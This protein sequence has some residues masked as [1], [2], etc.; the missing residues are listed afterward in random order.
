MAA[1]RVIVWGLGGMGSAAAAS[2]AAR[3]ADVIGLE[4]FHP[5]HDHGSSHGDSRIFRKAYFEHPD[6]V[7]LLDRAYDAWARLEA[8]TGEPLLN[9][10]G[11]LMIGAPDSAVVAG[12]LA[13]V[14]RWDLAHE[15]LDAAAMARRFPQFRLRPHD[16]A[17]FEADAGYLRP[18]VAVG[19]Q[20][21]R[22]E[23]AGAA[24]RFGVRATDWEPR[25]DGVAVAVDGETIEADH[26]VITA[27]AWA[28]T[29]LAASGFPLQAA[30]AVMYR[31]AP[32]DPAAFAPARFP[33]FVYD[34]RGSAGEDDAL[35]GV[36][37]LGALDAAG[38]T[39]PAAKVGFHYRLTPVDPDHVDRHVTAEEIAAIRAVLAERIPGLAGECVAATTCFYTMTPDEHFVIG[40]LPGAAGTVS[41][42]AGFSGHG[43]K[44][45]PI[46]GEILADL[47][48]DGTTTAPI[49]LFDPLRF[50][51]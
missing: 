5:V 24:L 33:A 7:P 25:G 28:G 36:G 41:V 32:D 2:L 42:A 37:D 46:V 45:T 30:R 29:A 10:C 49:A 22:A 23:A 17:V 21:R 44:F 27:G 26:L 50:T 39:V 38:N 35:Y 12:T 14:Q 15:S 51:R 43:F 13:S 40:P 16:V 3:G 8:A 18:E 11:A 1:P 34:T 47:A 9:R 4:R 20:L 19:A 6:Y 31:F 48:L